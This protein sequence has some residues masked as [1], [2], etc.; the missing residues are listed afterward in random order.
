MNYILEDYQEKIKQLIVNTP[1]VGVFAFMGVGKT[2]ATLDAI[3][4]LMYNRGTINKVLV[5]APIRVAK[6]TWTD[7][8]EKW[9]FPFTVSLI[10]GS[11]SKRE[12]A[13]KAEADIYVI[14]RENVVWLIDNYKK[15]WK[16]DMVVIDE[17]SSFK[18]SN[19]KRFKSLKS[20]L[21]KINRMVLL[22]GTPAPRGYIN[23]WS[24][25][26]LLDGGARLYPYKSYYTA[27]YFIPASGQ[28]NVT[29]S[30]ELKNG[31]DKI[32][33]RKLSDIC[34]GLS[35]PRLKDDTAKV[36]DVSVQLEANIMK[37][38]RQFK[39]EQI[40]EL[41]NEKEIVALNAAALSTKLLQM[42][43][44]AIY[45]DTDGN[46][47][48]LHDEKLEALQ[49]IIDSFDGENILVFITFKHEAERINGYFKDAEPLDVKKWNAGKQRI[50]YAHP[51]SCG[52]GLNL[53]SG[54][55]ICVWFSPT[56]DLELYQQ[57]NAR[58]DRKGQ[59]QNVL[60]Y[61][62]IAKGTRDEDAI[63]ALD[64][65]GITQ[66]DFIKSLLA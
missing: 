60:I 4:E 56:F 51:A 53:Q 58:L 61:R 13:V 12:R 9:N 24:Q 7:E 63:K 45:T 62:L 47:E 16:W 14:N 35:N 15:L 26:Y 22:T 36:I 48:H 66:Q 42:A 27:D 37:R 38:Y 28:G 18:N 39:R 6:Y 19:T 29:Y 43:S 34:Y 50:A 11:K 33:Q 46:W 23:L 54:G 10:L 8:I 55:H 2:L 44:G 21:G 25:I 32:I 1:K 59:K 17:S 30:W 49:E 3:D 5:I 52:H 31:A 20:V 41:Q 57:A 40:I 65:K 64:K